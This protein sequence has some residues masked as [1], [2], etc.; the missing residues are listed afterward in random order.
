[1]VS[2]DDLGIAEVASSYGASVPFLRGKKTADDYATTAEVL[3]E[4]LERYEAQGEVYDAV[5]CLYATAPF[6]TAEKLRAA[7]ST[8]DPHSCDEVLSVTEFSFPPMRGF[9][10]KDG[11][12]QY[13]FPEFAKSRSQDLEPMYQDAGQFYFYGAESRK[14]GA[15]CPVRRIGYVVPQTEVQ[16]I[17]NQVDWKL[18]EMKYLLMKDFDVLELEK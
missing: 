18:A 13:R 14:N 11:S 1:M 3:F 15:F 2:T 16:D 10:M 17:D 6:V 4:V 5:C 12:L 7:Y 8:F 9:V